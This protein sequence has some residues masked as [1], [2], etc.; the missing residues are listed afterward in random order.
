MKIGAVYP[1]TEL[2]G[3]P[4]AMRTVALAVEELGFDYL[5][6]YDHVLGAVHADREPPLPGPYTERDPFHDP[7]VMFGYL[8][9]ITQRI[10]FATG[11]IVLPQRQTAL[12]ARQATDVDLF[13]GGRLRLGV[14]VGWNHVEYEALGQDFGTRGARQEEQI[15]LLRRLFSD[16]VVDF[17]GRFDRVRRAA[18]LPRPTR[19]IPIWLGGSSEKAYDR[20]ARLADG[21]IYF[22]GRREVIVDRWRSLRGRVRELGRNLE[23]FGGEWV[24]PP[25]GGA[26][27]HAGAIE[28]WRE[29]GGTHA[30]VATMGLGLDSADAHVDYLASIARAL[31]LR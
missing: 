1:Q 10:E 2:R 15:E 7:L 22:A 29:A 11:V 21:F 16:P 18:L 14:G 25:L 28:A 31:S 27:E 8:A 17:T 30:A 12:V 5:L 6:A 19:P 23:D 24:P 13:S 26:A 20:A 4:A 9:G 3:D